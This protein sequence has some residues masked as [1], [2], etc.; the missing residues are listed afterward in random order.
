VSR[1]YKIQIEYYLSDENLKK[2][3]FFHQ[4]ILSNSE[5]YIDLDYF[6]K[7][8]KV[9]NAG[10]TKEELKEG[11]KE[12]KELELDK[13]TERV[14]R[15]N[16][17]ELPE[18]LLLNKKRKK[19][20]KEDENEE[21]E[22]EENESIDPTILKITSNEETKI[23]AEKLHHNTNFCP[24]EDLTVNGKIKTV[25]IR[26]NKLFDNYQMLPSLLTQ[27]EICLEE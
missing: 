10:W 13:T 23:K 1:L 24:F 26:G 5:G 27:K 16:N 11:I 21:K 6:L 18:L 4:K 20:E 8:N 17:K 25:F 15:I 2:D 12:S 19:E 3:Q 14:R 7:C 9:K 22:E